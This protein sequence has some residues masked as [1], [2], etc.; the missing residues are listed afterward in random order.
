M[1]LPTLI[2]FVSSFELIKYFGFHCQCEKSIW[3]EISV[4]NLFMSKRE[5]SCFNNFRFIHFPYVMFIALHLVFGLNFS[6][7]FY[8]FP[9]C[10]SV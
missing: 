10:T 2:Y 9:A 3:L 7:K 8:Y 6:L 5:S 1:G 4:L